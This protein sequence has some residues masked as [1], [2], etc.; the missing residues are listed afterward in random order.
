M[1]TITG[2]KLVIGDGFTC[3]SDTTIADIE[4]WDIEATGVIVEILSIHITSEVAGLSNIHIQ[5]IANAFLIQDM[6]LNLDNP[7]H[8]VYPRNA[9]PRLNGL[10]IDT[11]TFDASAVISY[12]IIYRVAGERSAV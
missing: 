1:A 9:M 2:D 5:D 12:S 10:T 6:Q 7:I 11:P 3:A 8:I 4:E